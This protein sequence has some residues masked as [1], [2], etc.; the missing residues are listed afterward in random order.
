MPQLHSKG[1]QKNGLPAASTKPTNGHSSHWA[2]SVIHT[3]FF[4][5][6]QMILNALLWSGLTDLMQIHISK[7]LDH[8]YNSWQV[9][10]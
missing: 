4:N 9:F 10:G 5:C 8:S 3:F 7:K 1:P 6:P 2:V